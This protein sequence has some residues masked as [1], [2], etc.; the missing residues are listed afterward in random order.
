M[1]IFHRLNTALALVTL[2][3]LSA[4]SS[5][6]DYARKVI[7]KDKLNQGAIM[8]NQGRT[9]EAQKYFKDALD[10]FDQNPVGWLYYGAT[11]VKDYKALSG[12]EREQKA[13]EALNAYQKALDLSGGNCKITDNAV[14]YMATIYE[15]L[16][17][18]NERRE[19][20]LKRAEHPECSSKD[21]KATTYYTIGVNYWNCSYDQT[22]RYQD[23]TKVTGDP[24]HARNMDYS[25]EAQAD[26]QR[27]QDCV[28]KGLE[29]IEKAL[30]VDPEYP[31]AY[32][33]KGLLYRER[34][35]MTKDEAERKKL[36]DMAQKLSEEGSAMQKKKEEAAKQKEQQSQPQG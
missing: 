7:A 5:G 23:K 15:D 11:L 24:F 4:L 16:D 1:K 27:A 34:Q 3:T 31:D 8:Y 35:K 22:T 9:K 20:L 13:T 17:K 10:T 36:A 33:Y 21:I 29:Y 12:S 32:F 28:T 26:K 14:S 18:P 6:C 2:V 19:W 25:P 30:A